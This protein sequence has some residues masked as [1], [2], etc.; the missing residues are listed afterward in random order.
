MR[1]DIALST[2]R[3]FEIGLVCSLYF[4]F[5]CG[6]WRAKTLK[7]RDREGDRV[8]YPD[9]VSWIQVLKALVGAFACTRVNL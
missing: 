9:Q 8:R 1:G 5:S 4:F 7:C 2:M 3:S 6:D